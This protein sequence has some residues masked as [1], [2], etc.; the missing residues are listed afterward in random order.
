MD[1]GGGPALEPAARH[2][3]RDAGYDAFAHAE[4]P[5]LVRFAWSLTGDLGAAEDVAQ[6]AL[7]VA[8]QRWDEVAGFDRPDVWVRRVVA[9]R[10]AGR[11][12]RS[13]RE[14]RAMAAGSGGRRR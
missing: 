3:S 4:R 2:G 14:L 12:R 13:G 5:R 1:G 10:A 6:E 9:N 11:A 8:W 7:I